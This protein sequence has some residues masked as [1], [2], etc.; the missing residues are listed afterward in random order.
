M[1][2]V[3][4][5]LATEMFEFNS[6]SQFSMADSLVIM[7]RPP[8]QDQEIWARFPKNLMITLGFS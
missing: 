2:M 8:I 4:K 3:D 5:Y 1:T 7:P 6:L